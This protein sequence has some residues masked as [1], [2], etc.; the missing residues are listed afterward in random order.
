MATTVGEASVKLTFD[1]KGA[2]SQL[3]SDV[4]SATKSA[5]KTISS[6]S[7]AVGNIAANAFT[8]VANV[9]RDSLEGGITRFDTINRF[10]KV[11]EAIGYSSEE[12]SES[13]KNVWNYVQ[14]LPTPFNEALSAVQ[15]L[16]SSTGSLEK[17]TKIYEAMNNALLSGG[18]EIGRQSQVMTQWLQAVSRGKFVGQEWNDMM[19]VM[20]GVIK[21]ATKDLLG[22]TAG[23]EQLREALSSGKI[24]M[25][26]FLDEIEKLNSEGA[27][28]FS[29]LAKQ[30]K[31]NTEGI[32][33]SLTTLRQS[34]ENVWM[35]VLKAIGD[36]NITNGLNSLKSMING[37]S[38]AL[39]KM[40]N[41]VK[42]N[43]DWL[44][45]LAGG[46]AV[47]VAAFAA[48][49]K[50][51]AIVKGLSVALTA[52]TS[53]I[54][55]ITVAIAAVAALV[56][57]NWDKIQPILQSVWE[58]IQVNILPAIQ[59]AINWIS[60]NVVPVVVNIFNQIQP[61]FQNIVTLVQNVWNTIVTVVN[62]LMPIIQ[63]V[64]SVIIAAVQN[65]IL[66][67]IGIVDFV[68]SSINNIL[69]AGV[70]AWENIISPI[71]SFVSAVVAN[72]ISFI[73]MLKTRIDSIVSGIRAFFSSAFAN[74]RAVV[75]NVIS[76]IVGFVT[77][78]PGKVRGSIDNIKSIFSNAFED[79]KRV[80][81]DAVNAIIEFITSIPSRIGD[82]GAQ[83]G[84]K[85]TG[86]VSGAIEGAKGAI[87]DLLSNIPG[88]ATGGYVHAT[89]GGTLA[90]IGEG[91]EDEFV[92]PRSQMIDILTGVATRPLPELKADNMRVDTGGVSIYNTFQIHNELDADG[93][94]RRINNSIRLAT[95]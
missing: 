31:V 93:I 89:P 45:P 61:I 46:V 78:V 58:W 44:L 21:A 56:V 83:I 43:K 36:D 12:A 41:W 22:A 90:V 48:V 64:L 39:V 84:S 23:E 94:G 49:G 60:A 5:E 70:W 20:P 52:L 82:I 54:G 79:A 75:S 37:V 28:S 35:N 88:L 18:A 62:N 40:V 85:I 13:V 29:P 53:P 38:E 74:I 19:E 63:P 27:D 15:R 68:V 4:S 51:I 77:G 57:M 24:T 69:S 72:I 14:G 7:V 34:V 59:A 10:P 33:T 6:W 32:S 3:K 17:A 66:T 55:L 8:K 9:I 1:A 67:I 16:A 30:A 71:V 87:A 25:S 26:E 73:V 86:G 80:V 42:S 11:M 76:A 65:A 47:F 92:I 91:G 81:S 2:A 95:V 50:A